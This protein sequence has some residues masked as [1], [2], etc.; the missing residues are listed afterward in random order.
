MAFQELLSEP[1]VSEL[2]AGFKTSLARIISSPEPVASPA[3]M[4]RQG[5]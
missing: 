3:G 4:T 2:I 1:G 5:T